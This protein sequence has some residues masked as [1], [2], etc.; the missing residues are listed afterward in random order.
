MKI[1][2]KLY[3][4][5]QVAVLLVTILSIPTTAKA[6]Y[7]DVDQIRYVTYDDNTV[8]ASGVNKD[9][10]IVIPPTVTYDN[11]TYT[12]TGIDA[13]DFFYNYSSRTITGV[14]IPSTV[15]R[16]NIREEDNID[17]VNADLTHITIASGNPRY[18]SR[19]NC[20]AIIETASNTLLIGC[21][22]TT[23]VPN[24]VT[25]IRAGAFYYCSGLTS[26]TLPNSL[27]TIGD[28]AF[29]GCSG[30][31]EITMS[32]SLTSIGFQAFYLCSNLTSSITLP[33]T[34]TSIG[35]AAFCE[36]SNLTSV[37][38]PNS[39]TTIGDGAF[40]NCSKLESVNIP[41]SV[42]EIGQN[43][44][45]NTKI[46]EDQ[47]G[48]VYVGNWVVGYK[49]DLPGDCIIK[50]GTIGIA[51]NTFD[52]HYYLESAIEP[53]FTNL[54]IPNSVLYIGHD[55]F[56]Y[57]GNM[58]DEGSYTVSPI[59]TIVIGES[60]KTIGS[61]SFYTGSQSRYNDHG[62]LIDGDVNLESITCLAKVPPQTS[63]AFASY[64]LD[65]PIYGWY[66]T[67]YVIYHR[68]PLY[69]PMESVEAYKSD[70]EWGRFQTIVGIE[71]RDPSDVNGDG[72]VSIADVNCIVHEILY[73]Y[74]TPNN[75]EYDVNGDGEVT[76]ADVNSVIDAI[77]GN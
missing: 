61:H 38:L 40:Y 77:I 67:D 36:C 30:L 5:L 17:V 37:T 70:E 65:N 41:S 75:L 76:I 68:V 33:N 48:I 29:Q 60:V 35:D 13:S 66:E 27:T 25:A 51:S 55:V 21:K 49:N 1:K 31:S 34:L 28:C 62:T 6:L 18:D 20:N 11:K 23:F 63:D 64:I 2:T 72:E 46:T 43:A 74:I 24:T 53:P 52:Y 32:N 71:V 44:F 26:I 8:C 47:H 19:D 57:Q 42:T 15:T 45:Y 58:Y 12:V 22:N 73:L 50:N 4:C 39:L 56:Y 10:D 14:S 7:F 9:G 16:I 3:S 69:V 54:V 59:K